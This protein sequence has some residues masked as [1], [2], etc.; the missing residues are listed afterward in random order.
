MQGLSVINPTLLTFHTSIFN[1]I[2]DLSIKRMRNGMP[3][4]QFMRVESS[5]SSR[6]VA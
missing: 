3:D 4:R 1:D 2:V 6:L 5:R